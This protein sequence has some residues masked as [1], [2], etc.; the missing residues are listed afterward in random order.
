MWAL[1]Y[2]P[3]WFGAI[4]T[5]LA[6]NPECPGAVSPTAALRTIL[7]ARADGIGAKARMRRK[8][9]GPRKDSAWD[10]FLPRSML[11][12][13]CAICSS[14]WEAQQLSTMK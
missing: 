8:K 6:A 13:P 9:E 7:A 2:T 11:Q 3:A 5:M 12:L 10:T 4:S 14:T 1:Y